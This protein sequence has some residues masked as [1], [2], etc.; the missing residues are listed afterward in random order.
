MLGGRADSLQ[1]LRERWTVGRRMDRARAESEPENR[2]QEQN[3]EQKWK[4]EPEMCWSH[5]YTFTARDSR[6]AFEVYCVSCKGV[7]SSQAE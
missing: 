4:S 2:I 1:S 3:T 6:E 7:C 5:F